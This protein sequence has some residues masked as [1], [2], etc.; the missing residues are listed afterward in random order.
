MIVGVLDRRRRL[1]EREVLAGKDGVEDDAH[2]RAD[3]EAGERD[4]ERA[5]GE[6]DR[7]G[8]RE[9]DAERQDED[10]RRDEHVAALAQVDLALNEVADADRGDHSVEDE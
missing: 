2:E 6:R 1:G 8:L 10:E 3:G 7:A 5:D 4:L 9:R